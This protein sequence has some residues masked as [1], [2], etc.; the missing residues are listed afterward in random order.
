MRF[1]YS[2]WQ[3]ILIFEL[4]LSLKDKQ[5]KLGQSLKIPLKI[6]FLQF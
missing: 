1:D 2:F 6:I 5:S 4:F 3:K